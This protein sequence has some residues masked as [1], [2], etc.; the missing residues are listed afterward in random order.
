MRHTR[1]REIVSRLQSD[2]ALSVGALARACGV[3]TATIRRDLVDLESDGVLNRVHGGAML[4][5]EA[6][7]DVDA[8]RGFETIAT[9]DVQDKRAV[10]RCA[11]EMVEDG[12]VVL[13]DIG[14]TAMMLALELRGRPITVITSS[15]A[16]LDVLRGDAHVDLIL[17][18][19]SVRSTYHSLV[20]VLTADAAAQVHARTAFLGASGVCTDGT[21]VDNSI[22][23]VPI[24]RAL[25]QAADQVVVLADQHKLPGMGTLKVL[26]AKAVHVLV[27]N[28]GADRATVAA[29][30]KA[31]V[32][33]RLA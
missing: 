10:A 14:T 20:G 7:V 2:D 16:V 6:R 4:A 13:L 11:A 23:E 30:R 22:V 25:A 21:I 15:L 19:G 27:T 32:E 31:G 9:K 18:G 17:L 28:R 26:E 29:C 1:H 5:A 8:E 33:V 24:K 3:S 12:D